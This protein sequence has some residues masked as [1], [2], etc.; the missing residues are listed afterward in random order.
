MK[1]NKASLLLALLLTIDS[2]FGFVGI[3]G[4]KVIGDNALVFPFIGEIHIEKMQDCGVFKDL[5]ILLLIPGKILNVCIIQYFAV[6][7]PCSGY[8]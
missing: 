1:K 3:I 6:F 2:Q 7:T 8:W 5:P 4:T